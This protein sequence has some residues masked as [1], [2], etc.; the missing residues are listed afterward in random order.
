M[1]FFFRFPYGHVNKKK[2]QNISSK[3]LSTAQELLSAHERKIK[4]YEH[5]WDYF[6]LTFHLPPLPFLPPQI[7]IHLSL[8][9]KLQHAGFFFLFKSGLCNL[10]CALKTTIKPHYKTDFPQRGITASRRLVALLL[11]QRKAPRLEDV[12]MAEGTSSSEAC[13]FSF[14]GDFSWGGNEREIPVC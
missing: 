14:L 1:Y 5:V 6:L 9:L 12:H 4:H 8:D 2:Q 13:R 7:P 3:V 11:H 10:M